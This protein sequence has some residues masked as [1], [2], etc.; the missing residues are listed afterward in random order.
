MTT[1]RCASLAFALSAGL[2]VTACGEST[3]TSE[4]SA[5]TG[6]AAVEQQAAVQDGATEAHQVAQSAGVPAP[7]SAAT[8]G[9]ANITIDDFLGFKVAGI[10]LDMLA[11][12][13]NAVLAADGWEGEVG[14]RMVF[15]DVYPNDIVKG[16]DKLHVFVY[17]HP[18]GSMRVYN[19]QMWNQ[20]EG[21]QDVKSWEAAL[22]E[23][24]G[25]P[26]HGGTDASDPSRPS[27]LMTWVVLDGTYRDPKDPL[28]PDSH[29]YC[30]RRYNPAD[31]LKSCGEMDKVYEELRRVNISQSTNRLDINLGGSDGMMKIDLVGDGLQK[32]AHAFN[33]LKP[34]IEAAVNALE[35][36]QEADVDF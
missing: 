34:R 6:S 35:N 22:T 4:V 17:Q 3:D 19:V 21:S 14:T 16:D 10:R 18:D 5:E 33:E 7:Q 30:F 36:A 26:T 29:P 13:A 15:T 1:M 8:G 9:D 11:E 31:V 25:E 24:Y 2:A 12:D 28:E 27:L 32:A 23:R 20:L